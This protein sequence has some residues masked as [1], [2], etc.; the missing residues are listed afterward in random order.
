MGMW[1]LNGKAQWYEMGGDHLYQILTAET[2]HTM[3]LVKKKEEKL[4]H[5]C[6]MRLSGIRVRLLTMH[7]RPS[8]NFH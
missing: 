3:M 5:P 1:I 2:T 8:Q 6:Y 4:G 7:N